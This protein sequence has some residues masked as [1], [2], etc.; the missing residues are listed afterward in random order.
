MQRI[1]QS[2]LFIMCTIIIILLTSCGNQM[3]DNNIEQTDNENLTSVDDGYVVETITP[4]VASTI[5]PA[6]SPTISPTVTPTISPTVTPTISPMV[7]P[8]I[9]ASDVNDQ[10]L[11]EVQK[12]IDELMPAFREMKKLISGGL[13]T[14]GAEVIED[15]NGD[16]YF[17]LQDD[18]YKSVEDIRTA[19]ESVL[20]ER[21]IMDNRYYRIIHGNY[22][23]YKDIDGKL[24]TAM[25]DY[26]VSHWYSEVL[27]IEQR[28]DTE[29][30][31]RMQCEDGEG[32]KDVL[33]TIKNID[34]NWR[35]DDF[36]YGS[37]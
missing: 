28:S 19:M 10:E 8:P 37:E 2:G 22:P 35:I 29:M 14:R 7:T 6:V 20:T 34:G 12:I 32:L 11:A 26:P 3:Q 15:E 5:T 30:I 36:K 1:M 16:I 18:V 25:M 21:F 24:C 17:V 33:V 27:G 23:L 31:L 13:D 4:S 9:T